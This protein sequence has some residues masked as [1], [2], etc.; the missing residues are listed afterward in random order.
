VGVT[1]GVTEGEAE[2]V[3]ELEGVA[4]FEGVEEMD[5]VGVAEGVTEA[6]VV[7]DFVGVIDAVGVGAVAQTSEDWIPLHPKVAPLGG[8][9]AM[10]VDRETP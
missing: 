8:K 3:T 1:E 6:E 5:I 9:L 4:L 10:A 7:A 2:R